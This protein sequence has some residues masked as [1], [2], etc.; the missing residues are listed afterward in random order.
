MPYQITWSRP[1]IISLE[2]AIQY[3]AIDR[4]QTAEAFA[5]VLRARSEGIFGL[6]RRAGMIYTAH[7]PKFLMLSAFFHLPMIALTITLVI[8][9]I[10]RASESLTRSRRDGCLLCLSHHRH[11]NLD[12]FPESCRSA[13]SDQ[14]Q[15]GIKG[16]AE[17]VED[18]F[19]HRS[20]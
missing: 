20:A 1:G 10:L 9:T 15:T 14:T 6:L 12:R 4:P 8:V 7:M 18:V 17:E 3:I 11:D 2:D 16:S 13:P 19:W 5:S